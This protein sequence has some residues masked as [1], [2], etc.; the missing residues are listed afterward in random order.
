VAK[1][2]ELDNT[3]FFIILMGNPLSGKSILASQFPSCWFVDLDFKLNSI[4]A[5]REQQ[6]LDFDFDVTQINEEETTDED[7]VKLVGKTFAS[8]TG[9][10]KVKKLATALCR[11]MPK[12]S[13]LVIDGLSR[14]GEML[15][16]H[17]E[18][19][20]GH[21]PLQIQDWGVFFDEM[22]EFCDRLTSPQ[23]VPNVILIAHDEIIE[24]KVTGAIRR[25]LLVSGRS[26]AR[27]PSLADEF[28]YLTQKSKRVKG[29]DIESTRTLQVFADSQ[30]GT[31][32]RSW[33]PN[34][35][36]PTYKKLKPYLEKSVGRTLP[37]PTWTPKGE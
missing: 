19:T 20:T 17:L 36:N 7:F 4:T 26:A 33:M 18:K 13:T 10:R 27:L 3:R 1:H 30:T 35:V 31:G 6:G 15:K 24:D 9:W 37:D 14:A 8:S 2:S 16:Y 34:I 32:S 28:W 23:T 5:I 29:G 11:K 25:Q 12:D 21:K 22:K